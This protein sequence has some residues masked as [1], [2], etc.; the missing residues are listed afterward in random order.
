MCFIGNNLCHFYVTNDFKLQ[1]KRN[2][3]IDELVND[4][5][6]IKENKVALVLNSGVEIIHLNQNEENKN[7]FL[8]LK[9]N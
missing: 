7:I 8:D 3:L 1:I 4:I 5:V 9:K 6:E 2:I